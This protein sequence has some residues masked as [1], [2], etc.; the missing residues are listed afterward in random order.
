MLGTV[1]YR[2][3]GMRIRIQGRC[4]LVGAAI[5][6]GKVFGEVGRRVGHRGCL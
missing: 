5:V 1:V 3:G 6:L 4:C 2:L